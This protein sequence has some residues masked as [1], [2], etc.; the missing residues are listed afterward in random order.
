M[1]IL[2]LFMVPLEHD[3]LVLQAL[4]LILQVHPGQVHLIQHPPQ[5]GDVGLHSQPHGQLV[6]VPEGHTGR[7]DRR[8]VG[9]GG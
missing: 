1:P 7:T 5:S 2:H 8:R 3:E 6:L 4:I 9:A